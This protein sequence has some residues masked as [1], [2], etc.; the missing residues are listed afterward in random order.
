MVHDSAVTLLKGVVA[1]L[2]GGVSRPHWPH[3]IHDQL[4]RSC[5][6][7]NHSTKHIGNSY[8]EVKQNDIGQWMVIM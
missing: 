5:S 4:N 7:L 3:L 8:R 6:C 2:I 1:P